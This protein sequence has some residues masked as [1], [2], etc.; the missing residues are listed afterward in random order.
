MRKLPHEASFIGKC[1][2]TSSEGL[3][4]CGVFDWFVAL[5]HQARKAVRVCARFVRRSLGT[6]V[7]LITRKASHA[8]RVRVM[9]IQDTQ[10]RRAE[11]TAITRSHG[12]YVPS[13]SA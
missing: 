4:Q 7:V 8:S 6:T 5:Q 11:S 13:A 12:V 10:A 9:R 3:E 1:L 2:D